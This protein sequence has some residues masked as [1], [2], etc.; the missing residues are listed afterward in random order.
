MKRS[1]WITALSGLAIALSMSAH[2][3]AQASLLS[4]KW[5]VLPDGKSTLALLT[6]SQSGDAVTG[7]WAP[8]KGE[9]CEIENGKVTGDTLTFSFMQSGKHF[10]AIG[11]ISGGT[12]SFELVGPKKWGK[13]ETIHGQAARGD[14]L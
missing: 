5:F 8:P 9:A 7:K 4:G 10:D 11:H 3:Q 14:G 6:L 2:V 13:P 12:M 1:M